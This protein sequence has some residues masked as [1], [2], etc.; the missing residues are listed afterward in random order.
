MNVAP[1]VLCY[2]H[3]WHESYNWYFDQNFLCQSLV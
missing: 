3:S 1:N 2:L